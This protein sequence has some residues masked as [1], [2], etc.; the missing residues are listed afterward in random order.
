MDWAVLAPAIFSLIGV[1]VGAAGSFGGV[2]VTQRTTRQQ[3]RAQLE[4]ARRTERKETILGYLDAVEDSW[5]L[6]DG[7]WG[8]R[9]LV[10]KKGEV[11]NDDADI[12]H[13]RHMRNHDVWYHQTRINLVMPK[14]VREAA[15]ALTNRIY[16]A[17][18]HPDRVASNLWQY[19]EPA[20]TAFLDAA[21]RDLGIEQLAVYGPG[22]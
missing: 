17:T 7:L 21:R 22:R 15:L 19:I 16:E 20:Q 8:R 1:A 11:L 13:E 14:P 9:P 10:S 2:L 3:A 12:E 4:T 18:F 5:M 6:M